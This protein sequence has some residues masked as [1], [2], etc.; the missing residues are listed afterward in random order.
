VPLPLLKLAKALARLKSPPHGRNRSPELLRPARGLPIAVLPSL[1]VDSWPLPR[2]RVAVAPSPSLPNSSEPG[3]TLACACLNSS[4]LT[5]VERRDA[6]RSRL[7]PSVRFRSNGPDRGILLRASAPDALTHLSVP[8]TAAHLF[9]SD[10]SP[11]NSYRMARTP[12]GPARTPLGPVRTPFGPPPSDLDQTIQTPL[13]PCSHLFPL[14]HWARSV[15]T[16]SPPCR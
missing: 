8:P 11:S 6:N 12:L 3:A 1:P 13:D 14:W 5:A 9:R 4:D 15:S 10:F 7:I 2:H 16:L